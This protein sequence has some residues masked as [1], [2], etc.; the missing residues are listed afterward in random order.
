MYIDPS[1]FVLGSN[2]LVR[3]ENQRIITAPIR[4]QHIRSVFLFFTETL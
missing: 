3:G 1:H 2:P 4:F